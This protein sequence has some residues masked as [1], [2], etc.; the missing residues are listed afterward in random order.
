M[1]S[2]VLSI[3]AAAPSAQLPLMPVFRATSAPDTTIYGPMVPQDAALIS[4]AAAHASQD[5]GD[6]KICVSITGPPKCHDP[7]NRDFTDCVIHVRDCDEFKISDINVSDDD[8]DMDND[9][10]IAS[11]DEGSMYDDDNNDS[12]DDEDMLTGSE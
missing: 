3:M 9:G 5:L 8:T 7:D 11:D 6:K 4:A 10:W 1:A 12:D 2:S